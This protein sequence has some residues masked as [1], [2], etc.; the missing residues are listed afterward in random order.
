MSDALRCEVFYR[1][2]PDA[3]VA[4]DREPDAENGGRGGES[5]GGGLPAAV[6]LAC[7]AIDVAADPAAAARL[8]RL[9]IAVPADLP[10]ILLSSGD[11]RLRLQGVR[12]SA[13]EAVALAAGRGWRP[14]A[15]TAYVASWCGDCRRLK[16]LLGEAAL[17]CAEVDIE[18]EPDAEAEVL[19]RSGGRRVVPTLVLDGRVWAFNPEPALLRRLL[20]S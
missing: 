10:A 20:S 4:P 7:G 3:G 6:V 18:Q 17:P 14:Q 16:R 5:G 8:A 12:L 2:L 1:P 11:G 9:G 15:L 13:E 19:R